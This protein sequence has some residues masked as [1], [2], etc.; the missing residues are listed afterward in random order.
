[1]SQEIEIEF[2]NLLVKEEYERLLTALPFEQ[3]EQVRQVNH[4]FE[5]ADF[6]LKKRG[7]ALR[8]REKN[9]SYT[10]TLK[11]PHPDGLLE[12]HSPLTNEDAE[13]WMTGLEQVGNDVLARLHSMDIDVKELNYAGALTTVRKELELDEVLV[14]LDYSTYHGTEDF[15]LELEASERSVGEKA[16]H[17]LLTEHEIPE[18]ETPNKIQRFFSKK[19]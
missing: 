7:A 13:K 9:G 15:E 10:L 1:M 8:I 11:E 4:Y 6:Q 16:F 18:R 12:T 14:V 17:K 19:P 5:T 2:K 3:V